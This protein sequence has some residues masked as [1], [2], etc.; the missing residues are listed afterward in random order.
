M[1]LLKNV[2][3]ILMS[4]SLA[5][6]S[7]FQ[8]MDSWGQEKLPVHYMDARSPEG[9]RDL[10]HYDGHTVPFLSSHRGGPESDL[11]ENCIPT[12]ENTF[13]YTW[14]VLEIDPRYTKDSI[15]VLHHDPDLERTTTGKG[16]GTVRRST[17]WKTRLAYPPRGR[18]G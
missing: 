18:W 3:Q 13:R 6:F 2:G 7:L 11:P 4:A 17:V 8:V 10:F 12:F 5:V 15:M 9:L 1:R 16:R 14:S